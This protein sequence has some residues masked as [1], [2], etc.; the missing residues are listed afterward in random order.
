MLSMAPR[1]VGI[2][3]DTFAGDGE[4]IHVEFVQVHTTEAVDEICDQRGLCYR[5][6]GNKRQRPSAHGGEQ[7]KSAPGKKPETPG[8]FRLVQ[9]LPV[10]GFEPLAPSVAFRPSTDAA[11]R[12]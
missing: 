6:D 7:E 3:I 4:P 9:T 8:R 2:L 11:N 12:D 10:G 1:P 5:R